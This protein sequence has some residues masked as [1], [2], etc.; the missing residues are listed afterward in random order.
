MGGH[1]ER[2]LAKIW[3]EFLAV[4]PV[5]VD[6]DFFDLGGHSL[7]AVQMI[8]AVR[9]AFGVEVPVRSVMRTRTVSQAAAVIDALIWAREGADSTG[10]HGAA[11]REEGEV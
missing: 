7:L 4:E 9:D 8:S 2:A 11:A 10:S 5:G 6:D 3:S 1:T